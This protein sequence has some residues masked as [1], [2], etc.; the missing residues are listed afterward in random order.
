MG[1]KKSARYD[2]LI[3]EGQVMPEVWDDHECRILQMNEVV[4]IL[5]S[6]AESPNAGA[7]HG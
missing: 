4:K 3:R 7:S 6:V 1:E 5:N 2:L